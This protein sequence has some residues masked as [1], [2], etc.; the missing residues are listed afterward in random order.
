MRAELRQITITSKVWHLVGMDLIGQLKTT[1]KGNKYILT[2]VD[3]YSKWC[4]AIPISN[5]EA[6]TVVA[7]LSDVFARNS[8]PSRIISDN[9]GEFTSDV[10]AV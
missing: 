1:I 3:Y 7:A 9:G 2:L 10:G 5:K 4:E 8:T 6:Q